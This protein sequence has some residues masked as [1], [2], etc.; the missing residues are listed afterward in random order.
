M[1]ELVYSLS[2]DKLLEL[3]N[4]IAEAGILQELGGNPNRYFKDKKR[5]SKGNLKQ[6]YSILAKLDKKE[7]DKVFKKVVS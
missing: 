1:E 4:T 2:K 3:L 5:K 6:I 7:L